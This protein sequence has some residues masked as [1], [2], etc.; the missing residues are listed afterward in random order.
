MAAS[1]SSPVARTDLAIVA[2]AALWLLAWRALLDTPWGFAP[3]PAAGGL[4]SVGI[5]CNPGDT[6]SYLSWVQQYHHG[7]PLAGLL[8]TTEPHAPLLWLFPLWLVGKVAAVTG[9]SVIGTYNAAGVVG[10]M[11]AGYCFLRAAAALRLPPSARQWAAVALLLGSGGSWLWHLAHKFGWAPRA[12]G[13]DLFFLDLFPATAL[14]A[15]AYHAL[16]LALLAALWWCATEFDSHRLAGDAATRWLLGMMASGLLLGFS[17]PYEPLAFLGAWWLKA[18]WHLLHRHRQPAEWR[19][20]AA[21]GVLLAAA[22][23]PGIGWTAWVSTQPVWSGFAHES[24]AL[25]LNRT[26]WVWGLG[27]WAVLAALGWGPAWRAGPRLAVLPGAASVLLALVLFGLGSAHAKLASGLMFG[28]CL[29]AGWGAARLVTA[30]GR[31][32]GP[33]R[34]GVCGLSLAALLGVP[35]LFMNLNAIKLSGPALVDADLLALAQQIPFAA[36]GAAPVVLT[37]ATSGGILPGLIGARVWVGHWSLSGHYQ[38]KVARLRAAGLDPAFPPA[39]PV[40][41]G[42]ACAAILA[43]APFD[44]ALLDRRCANVLILLAARGWQPV[45]ATARWSLFRAPSPHP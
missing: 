10:A 38:A 18:G 33:I 37:D 45:A 1:P 14:L 13:S 3:V 26:A 30:A 11:A 4:V 17:R 24:L 15:Y 42:T 25:G 12:D 36:G 31:L 22:L 29:L 8:Y 32:P 39:D 6:F 2:L 28:P 43:D 7:A 19:S 23:I 16:G 21:T 35:S 40:S 9:W 20:A 41:A 34:V 27:G 44:Y 5:V